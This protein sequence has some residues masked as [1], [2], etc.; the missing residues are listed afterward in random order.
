MRPGAVFRPL[1][2]QKTIEELLRRSDLSGDGLSASRETVN[3]STN[4]VP[5]VTSRSAAGV[6]AGDRSKG[7]GLTKPERSLRGVRKAGRVGE[8]VPGCVAEPAEQEER[9]RAESDRG[10]RDRQKGDPE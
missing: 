6:V 10:E 3:I 1:A 4:R 7:V 8:S 5:P 9:N 2:R